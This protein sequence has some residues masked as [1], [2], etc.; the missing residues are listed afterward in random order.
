M[1]S[2]ITGVMKRNAGVA[3]P[4]IKA[5]DR[6]RT[7]EI[8]RTIRFLTTQTA[9]AALNPTS[10]VKLNVDQYEYRA[11]R[12]L[13]LLMKKNDS[14]DRRLTSHANNNPDSTPPAKN[15]PSTR[16]SDREF[17]YTVRGFISAHA[18]QTMLRQFPRLYARAESGRT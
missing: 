8:R 1:W 16:K 15:H 2:F 11:I 5:A 9:Y 7:R 18:A 17:V 3:R 10:C 13:S 6:R 14:N 4:T 12:N